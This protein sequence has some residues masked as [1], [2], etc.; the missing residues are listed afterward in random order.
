MKIIHTKLSNNSYDIYIEKGLLNTLGE[1]LQAWYKGSAIAVV[2]DQTV[3]KLHGA[4]IVSALSKAGYRVSKTVI[5][6][7]ELSKSLTSLNYV[8]NK[9]A[10]S[11]IDRNSLIIAFGG[12]VV[13]DLVGFAA[14]TYMRG[15]P[16]VQIPTTVM[17]QLDSSIGG[18]TAVNLEAGKNLAGCF[19]HPK[20][21]YIDPS[22]LATLHERAYSDGLAEAIKYGA[23]KDTS[24][25]Q[26]MLNANSLKALQNSIEDIMYNCC[27]IK[28]K[29]VEKDELDNGERQLLNFGHTIGHGIEKYFDFQSYTHG[30]AV[31]LG[32]L[33]ITK[34]SEA[35]G[36]TKVGSHKAIVEL[37]NICKLPTEMPRMDYSKLLNIIYRDKKSKNDYINLILLNKIGDAYI[38]QTLKADMDSFIL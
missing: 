20:A 27:S 32:M 14:A 15:V 33:Q 25:F 30:E 28:T 26:F 3:D 21:V 37:L 29:L 10:E 6:P 8:Y 35:M 9:L 13:G 31:G 19:Y 24:L 4:S 16:Y 1:Q 38:H 11:E 23:I 12:G 5:A 18:K 36:L 17:S 7:G 22:L 2:T 34:C